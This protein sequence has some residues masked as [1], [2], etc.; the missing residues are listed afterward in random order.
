MP[1]HSQMV[2]AELHTPF[3]YVS[4]SD[5]G[6]V[7]AG[8]YWVDLTN[9]KLFRRN[10]GNTDWDEIGGP[11]SIAFPDLTD[12]PNSYSGQ[13]AKAVRVKG[14]EDGLEF[15]TL[16]NVTAFL[17]LSD[18]PASYSG[19][20]L[21][22]VRVNAGETALEFQTFPTLVTAFT[23]LSDVP[24]SYSGQGLKYV[25]VNTG[26]TALEF[27]APLVVAPAFVTETD[28]AT[29]TITMDV[30]KAVQNST[31]TLGGNRTL[32]FSGHVNG[33]TGTLIVKQDGTGSRTLALP[34]TSKVNG[35]GAGV[36]T[37]TTTASAIDILSW[38]YDGTNIL[39]TYGNDFT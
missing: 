5:P 22:Y 13:A 38:V 25:R 36:I 34:A 39:W 14:A 30:S 29:I 19:Q 10:S 11:G 20:T 23:A 17:E 1:I 12:V 24:A 3:Q 31:V 28:G 21:K 2:G 18:V 27:V 4:S 15:F 26:A 35:T 6:A 8:V 9:F 7:G 33:M 32:A 37:L 16:S